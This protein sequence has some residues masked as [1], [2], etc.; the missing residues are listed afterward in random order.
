M[1]VSDL[2]LTGLFSSLL[3]CFDGLFCVITEFPHLLT[4]C[5][6]FVRI[7]QLHH[8]FVKAIF[9]YLLKRI[10]RFFIHLFYIRISLDVMDNIIISGYNKVKQSVDPSI[11]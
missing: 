9:Q 3:A 11:T 5:V 6:L 2:D 7:S 10:L 1:P 8:R 4:D